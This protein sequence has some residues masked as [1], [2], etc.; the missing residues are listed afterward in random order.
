MRLTLHVNLPSNIPSFAAGKLA[1]CLLFAI[2]SFTPCT[3]RLAALANYLKFTKS[4]K[5]ER[6]K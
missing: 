4:A 5:V 6:F 1:D 3:V 2:D